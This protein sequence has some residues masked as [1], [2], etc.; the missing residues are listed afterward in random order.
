MGDS[1]ATGV[2]IRAM[3]TQKQEK[4]IVYLV[5]TVHVSEASAHKVEDTIRMVLP[6]MVCLELDLKRFKV[7]QEG[8]SGGTGM[9]AMGG[10]DKTQEPITTE[11]SL[12]GT[13]HFRYSKCVECPKV[14]CPKRFVSKE[15]GGVRFLSK[16]DKGIA[17]DE[18][19]VGGKGMRGV[20]VDVKL[21]TTQSMRISP[22]KEVSDNKVRYYNSDAEKTQKNKGSFKSEG[23]NISDLFSV[24]GLLKW[25]QQEIGEEFG[26]MP[27]TEMVTALQT[28]KG[29]GLNIGLVDRPVEITLARMW[30]SMGFGEKI[31]LFSYLFGAAGFLAMRPLFGKGL[32]GVG[33][34]FGEGKELDIKKLEKGEG[35][36]GMMD[37]L[38]QKFPTVYRALVDERNE[39][40]CK[41]IMGIFARGMK[42]LVVVVGLGHA[43]GMK[44]ILESK[45]IEVKLV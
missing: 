36:D 6:D 2:A 33:S 37:I 39:Y 32:G 4:R 5:G 16:E 3:P 30:G 27:G 15:E 29:F 28:A 44:R 12:G 42:T 11:R 20:G 41:N 22:P 10:Y 18:S 1:N 38:K 43:S 31:R 21:G 25:M 24:Q 9:P 23:F 13:G 40:M 35:V 45:G 26:V 14:E 7:M 8:L 17:V 19:D 34:V